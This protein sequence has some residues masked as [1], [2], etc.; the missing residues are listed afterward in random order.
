MTLQATHIQILVP[1]T[2]HA[3]QIMKY[4][5]FGICIPLGEGWWVVVNLKGNM[6]D[7]VG[8]IGQVIRQVIVRHR[9]RASF[10]FF[11]GNLTLWPSYTPCSSL[12][13]A[14]SVPKNFSQIWGTWSC[15]MR[16]NSIGELSTT[17]SAQLFLLV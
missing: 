4:L 5:T 17:R 7:R 11:R 15:H 9:R 2:L 13:A 12:L 1:L 6:C 8:M 3:S 10:F 16:R 14:R